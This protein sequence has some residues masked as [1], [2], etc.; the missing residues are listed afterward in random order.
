MTLCRHVSACPEHRCSE[1]L[2][3]ASSPDIDCWRQ[4]LYSKDLYN[5]SPAHVR[6]LRK[7]LPVNSN[8]FCF[9]PVWKVA[10]FFLLLALFVF[11]SDY[12]E[13]L[14]ALVEPQFAS[15]FGVAESRCT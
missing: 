10:G 12:C 3:H 5:S 4:T 8:A 15:R 2:M 7:M 1:H 6:S 11:R 14:L 13:R 9:L